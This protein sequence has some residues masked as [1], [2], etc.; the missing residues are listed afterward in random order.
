MAIMLITAKGLTTDHKALLMGYRKG[1]LTTIRIALMGFTFGYYLHLGLM[2]AVNFVFTM[3]RL[4]E[5]TLGAKTSC[6]E[7]AAL[8][9]K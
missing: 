9:G 3:T 6:K 7:Q 8:D 2:D 5:Q 1:N 4:L